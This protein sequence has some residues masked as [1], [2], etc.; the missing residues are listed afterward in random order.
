[1]VMDIKGEQRAVQKVFCD[2]FVLRVPDYQRPYAWRAEQAEELL[3]DLLSFLGEVATPVADLPAYFLGCVVLVKSEGRAES[4]IIDG[5]QRITTLT[6][7]LAVLRQMTSAAFGA[8]LTRYLYQPGSQVEGTQNQYRLHLR[9]K[10]DAFFR[11]HVQAEGGLEKLAGLSIELSDS[12]QRMRENARCFQDKLAA[13]TVEQRERLARYLIQRCFL[14]VVSVGDRDSA[15]RIFSVLN[16]RGLDL[17]HADILKAE[18]IGKLASEAQQAS[19]ASKWEAVESDLGRDAF[20]ILFA[21]LRMIYRRARPEGTILAEFRKYVVEKIGDPRVLIDDVIVASA[22]AFD[23]I[24]ECSWDGTAPAVTKKKIEELLEWLKRLDNE[25]WVPIAIQIMRFGDD[26]AKVLRHLEALERLAAY[27]FICRL[28]VNAR[29]ARYAKVLVAMAEGRDV[30]DMPALALDATEQSKFIEKLQGEV[31]VEDKTRMYVLLR[32]DRALGDGA[33]LYYS[34]TVTIEHVLPQNPKEGSEWLR[35][36]ATPADRKWTHRLGN[37]L[38]L[39]LR[40]NVSAGT[41]DFAEKKKSY[42]S[43][44]HGVSTFAITSGVLQEDAWTPE[45]V[46]RRQRGAVAVLKEVWA[47]AEPSM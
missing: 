34:K 28:N 29:V 27:M 39:P 13:K 43:S 21:H 3:E 37:L 26:G 22:R 30:A 33:A 24:R 44:K 14:V 25:D 8:D 17:S 45:V 7:L 40:K 19:Y 47:L 1:M 11:E 42:F 18:L 6:I 4:E 12:Q 31:Y 20:K 46:E 2:D 35:N 41:L 32:L 36:F 38:L 5:Q 23:Q 15:Y 9:R 16:D 10:D